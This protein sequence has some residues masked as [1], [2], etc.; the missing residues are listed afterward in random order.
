MERSWSFHHAP[1]PDAF[2]R[3]LVMRKMRDVGFVGFLCSVFRSIVEAG[4]TE[5]S[6][7]FGGG[8]AEGGADGC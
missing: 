2:A 6:T 7:T 4:P 3:T 8:C 1:N 5:P